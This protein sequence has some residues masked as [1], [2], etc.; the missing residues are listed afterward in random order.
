M[1]E[2][3][4]LNKCLENLQSYSIVDTGCPNTSLNTSTTNT[5]AYGWIVEVVVAR[6]RLG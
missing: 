6:K 5:Y 1:K 3:G 4:F 2:C